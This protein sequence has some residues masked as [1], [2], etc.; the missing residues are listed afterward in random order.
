MWRKVLFS[1]FILCELFVTSAAAQIIAQEKSYS[2]DRFDVDVV[3]QEDG[4]L[5]V[6]ETVVFTFVGQ[7]FTFVFRELPTDH[8]DGIT[9]IV[10][11]VDGRL[12]PQGTNAGQ[13]EISGRDPIRVEYH[14]EPTVD[15]TRTFVLQ[16]TMLGVVRQEN[17]ADLLLY[18]PLP[19][20]YDYAIVN[21]VVTV[22]V[23]ETAV[24]ATPPTLTA[25]NAQVDENGNQFTFRKQN[26]SPNEPLVFNMRFQPGTLITAAPNWQ[27][28]QA[29]QAALIP[30][31]MGLAV[32]ILAVG[33]WLIVR[34]WQQH[35][36]AISTTKAIAY[37]PP[38]NLPP[39]FAGVLLTTGAEPGWAHALGTLFDL[40]D[41][42]VL[43]IDEQPDKKWYQSHD[44]VIRLVAK[45][46]DSRPHEQA[47]QEL[48][49]QTKKGWTDEM[50]MSKLSRQVNTSR[51]KAFTK[52]L[53]AELAAAGT[54]SQERQQ[55]RTRLA[56]WG[57]LLMVLMFAFSIPVIVLQSQVGVWPL[58]VSGSLFF[59][60][61]MALLFSANLSP[62][63]DQAAET[64]VSWQPFKN[65][66]QQI[67]RK[68]A[69]ITRPDIFELYL[70]YAA[71]FGYLHNWARRFE[72]EG[73]TRLPHYFHALPGS[74]N[75]MA[76]FVAM[77][78]ATTSSS[79]AATG[80]GAAGAGAAGGG[81]SGAG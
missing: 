6:T 69:A 40:A 74:N 73:V 23:P 41:R 5:L 52:T 76:A 30:V 58:V 21:S 14:F 57:I 8:T 38:G 34:Y 27:Q 68:K 25:G 67:S 17:G 28:Q 56:V 24:L 50:K 55:A 44:F 54:F 39:A 22:T 79:G 49:F 42:G 62:L 29:R 32:V 46:S 61:L 33:A 4:S 10:A 51:W 80:A 64:A 2:A 16:Y 71:A 45:Q 19:D 65:Y 3:V 53:K 13:V 11:R 81:A 77:T 59:L 48:L 9:D 43:Q 15:S 47:L 78:A 20:S 35:R 72:K 70:P 12:Y 31:W 18:Q 60:M 75:Q 7:P 66:L 63:S 37:D 1:L 36:P 26:L